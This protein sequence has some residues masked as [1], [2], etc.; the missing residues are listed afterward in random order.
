MLDL[1]DPQ[2]WNGYSYVNN[3]P[4]SRTD[5]DGRG[6]FKKL[7][8]KIRWGVWG[9][10]ADVEAEEKRRRQFLYDNSFT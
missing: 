6:F 9:E 2:S 7:W 8:N 3:N 1:S 5:D 10:D 4:P